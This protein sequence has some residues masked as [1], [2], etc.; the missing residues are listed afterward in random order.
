MLILLASGIALRGLAGGPALYRR[1]N[2]RDGRHRSDQRLLP[3]LVKRDFADRVPL[4]TG[5]YTMAFCA[6]AAGAA[7]TTVPL[8]EAFG[9]SWP[10]ALAFW[11]LPAVLAALVWATQLPRRNPA[12]AHAAFVSGDSGPT[13]WLGT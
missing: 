9:G 3:G 13:R 11:S 7:G 1:P 6:G 5:L 12:G 10:A 2:S 4:M 8:A